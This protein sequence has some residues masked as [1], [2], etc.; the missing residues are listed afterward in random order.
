MSETVLTS[1]Q[2][3]SS[4]SRK[5]QIVI[6]SRRHPNLTSPPTVHSKDSKPSSKERTKRRK[7][8]EIQS[9]KG[10]FP[11]P[12][13]P[14]ILYTDTDGFR[15]LLIGSPTRQHRRSTDIRLQCHPKEERISQP[16]QTIQ[17]HRRRSEPCRD[18][19]NHASGYRKHVI[20]RERNG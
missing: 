6:T 3:P 9:Q 5:V 17:S 10:S 15:V 13:S 16:T 1:T 8:R 19:R 2:K 20:S 7:R 4:N 12:S 11:A 14:R 18:S